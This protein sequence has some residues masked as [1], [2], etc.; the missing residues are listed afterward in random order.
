MGDYQ[1][2]SPAETQEVAARFSDALHG[3]EVIAF[4]GEIGAGKTTFV[5]GLAKALGSEEAVTSPTFA[6]QNRYAGRLVLKHYDMYRIQD[7][8]SLY[9]TGFFDDLG[10]PDTV[11]LIEWSEHIKEAL[12]NEHIQIDIARGA[13]DTDRTIRIKWMTGET[14]DAAAGS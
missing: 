7:W 11:L 12:P 5:Q 3:G 4:T 2:H 8:D 10:Q 6:I 14:N 13:G 9:F 1:T